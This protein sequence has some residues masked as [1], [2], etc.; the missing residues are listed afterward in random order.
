MSGPSGVGKSTMA[1]DIV[2]TMQSV[3]KTCVIFSTD[4]YW[5]RPDGRYDWNFT[6]I[7]EAHEWNYKKFAEFVTNEDFQKHDVTAIIDNTNL[8]FFEYQRY[9]FLAQKHG[10]SIELKYVNCPFTAEQLA[11]RTTHN[12]PLKSIQRMLDRW[13]SKE[14]MERQ[15]F[16]L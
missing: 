7:E 16:G 10:W 6:L 9:V 11:L 3:G 5:I 1:M 2:R 14:E 12:V 15:I 4:N 13:E 8:K